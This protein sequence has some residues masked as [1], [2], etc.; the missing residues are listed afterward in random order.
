MI[1]YHASNI[2][3]LKE[4]LPLSKDKDSGEKVAYFTPLR[5]YA[6]FYLRDMEVN[7]VSA[8]MV[9]DS[10]IISHEFFQ[11]QLRILYQGRSGYIYACEN[12]DNITL[13]HT[14]GIWLAKEPIGV[15]ATEYID[16]VYEHIM[17]EVAAGTVELIRYESLSEEKKQEVTEVTKKD[18]LANN[19]LTTDS[20]K[21]RFWAKHYPQAW[22][23]AEAEKADKNR[24]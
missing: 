2:G 14:I 16:D 21:S 24:K 3:N 17:Q 22:E 1:F 12:D 11:D 19:F 8:G 5:A 6:L 20:A 10:K 23:L 4:I 13:A 7:H 9:S 15:T 18:I